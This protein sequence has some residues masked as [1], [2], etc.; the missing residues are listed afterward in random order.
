MVSTK[1]MV[2]G[3]AQLRDR[4][5][6]R[7]DPLLR[8]I[9]G[10]VNE[11]HRAIEQGDLDALGRAMN[12]NQALLETLQLSTDR[13][14]SACKIARDSGALGA[15]LTGKGGGGCVVALC[16]NSPEEVLAAWRAHAIECF[17]TTISA[18][19]GIAVQ[20]AAP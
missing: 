19:P 6:S 11:A 16:R 17:S 10:L 2:T 1:V 18:H 15:K 14:E 5:S 7:V 3:L 13:L 20:A 8:E 4:D 12:R 9:G